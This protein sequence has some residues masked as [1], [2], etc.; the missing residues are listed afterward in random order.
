MSGFLLLHGASS[1]GWL[2]HRV[3]AELRRS[4]HETVAPDLPCSDP[5]A[6]LNTYVDVACDA[7]TPFGDEPVVVVAQSMA[8]LIAPV[9]ATRRPVEMIVLVAGMI[10]RPGET[11]MKWW[12]ATGQAAAQREH[13]DALGFAGCDPLD[14]EI[15]FIHD[16]DPQL[17]AES[18]AH[19]P[20]QHPGPLS[21]PCP[22]DVWPSIP[23]HVIAAE[24][25]RLFPLE[26]MRSQAMDRL[27]LGVDVI[28]GG[29]LAALTQPKE[30]V[31]LLSQY[32]H[33]LRQVK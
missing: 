2:W 21:T 4:G 11:G 32:H 29:H 3:E 17:K 8:G 14:P 27:G 31:G 18:I 19:V 1:T 22:F 33:E 24:S 5:K 7:V 28:P 25:D 9:V 12:E 20:I 13:L 15:V 16:F 6:D 26:F 23:T 30:L 10:P